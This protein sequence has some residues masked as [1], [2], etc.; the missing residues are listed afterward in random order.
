MNKVL[1]ALANFSPQLEQSLSGQQQRALDDLGA[2]RSASLGGHVQKCPQCEQI[3]VYYNSCRNRHCPQCQGL[4]KAIWVDKITTD[5]LNSSYFHLVFTVP[6][7]LKGLIYKNQKLLYALF[8]RASA[9]TITELCQDKHYLGA[10]PGF[11]SMLHT[12]SQDLHYHPHIHS[13][14]TGGGLTDNRQWRMSKKKFFIPVKVLSKKFRGKFL[15]YLKKVYAENKGG[16]YLPASYR[17]A[18]DF[19][20]LIDRLYCLDWYSYVQ[21]TYGKPQAL[22]KYLGRYAS[23][24]AISSSRLVE[25]TKV[26]VSFKVRDRKAPARQ[27]V[28]SLQG[29]EFVRR[30]LLHILPR[31]FVKIRYYGIQAVRNKKTKLA[32]CRR[33]SNSKVYFSRYEGLSKVAVA[34]LLAGRDLRLCSSCRVG[35]MEFFETLPPQVDT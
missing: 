21:E 10:Q 13:V 9:E 16:L 4:N 14:V 17:E 12:W 7:E 6:E 28:M 24:V 32:L 3:K 11:F 20:A 30:F 27:R 8:Y 22:L 33:L 26:T 1:A 34:S 31:G 5:V 2:C 25:V 15:F 19:Q 23:G 29:K 18:K 35:K